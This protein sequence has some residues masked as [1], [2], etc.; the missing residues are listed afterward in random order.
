MPVEHLA[1]HFACFQRL[2]GIAVEAG[3]HLLPDGVVASL[4]MLPADVRLIIFPSLS[5][6]GAMWKK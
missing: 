1:Q 5:R 2:F 4:E 6:K 3:G